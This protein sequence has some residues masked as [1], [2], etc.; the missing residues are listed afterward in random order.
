MI[1]SIDK[2]KTFDKTQHTFMKKTFSKLEIE[3][4]CLNLHQCKEH[5][6]KT[7]SYFFLKSKPTVK[8]FLIMRNLKI[9]H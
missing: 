5:V 4:S 3:G 2:E 6:Q 1:I 9:S 7:Y 8:F